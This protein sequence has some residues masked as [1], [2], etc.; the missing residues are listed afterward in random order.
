MV[1][2]V[3]DAIEALIDFREERLHLGIS[4]AKQYD[5]LRDPGKSRLRDLHDTL[6]RA[7]LDTYGFVA[8]DPLSEL[9]ALTLG[10][11]AK[12]HAGEQVR[13]PGGH[14]LRGARRTNVAVTAD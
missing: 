12:E 4:L 10:L 7:V 8:S 9:L 2:S 11:A 14:G 1:K 6:D 13:G 3:V 5:S